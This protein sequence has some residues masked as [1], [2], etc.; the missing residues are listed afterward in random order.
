MSFIYLLRPL[1]F[2]GV[3]RNKPLYSYTCFD[4]EGKQYV[5]IKYCIYSQPRFISRNW[6]MC[7]MSLFC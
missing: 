7:Q 4:C 2:N 1:K 5:Y 3:E 6:T